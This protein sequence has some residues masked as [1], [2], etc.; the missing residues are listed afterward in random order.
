MDNRDHMLISWPS[1][2]IEGIIFPVIQDLSERFKIIVFVLSIPNSDSMKTKL[3]SMLKKKV[4]VDY[5]I[6]PKMMKGFLFHLYMKKSINLLKKYR[7]KLWLCSSDMQITE[8]YISDNSLELNVKK[9]CLWPPITYLFMYNQALAKQLL[10]DYEF[11]EEIIDSNQSSI[12]NKFRNAYSRNKSLMSSIKYM[13]LKKAIIFRFFSIK[14]RKYLSHVLNRY[15][16]PLLMVGKI[17]GTSKLERMTQLSSG[18]ATAYIFF[19]DYEVKAHKKLYR[20]NNIFLSYIRKSSEDKYADKKILG[21]LS[22]WETHKLLEQNILD[23]YVNDFIK[24]CELYNTNSIDLRPHPDMHPNSN[25]ASQIVEALVSKGINCEITS[26]DSPVI[27]QSEKYICV[28]GFASASLRDI[29]L[30]NQSIGVIGFES[31]SKHY[32]SDPKFAF[33]SSDGIDWLNSN[34]DIVKSNKLNLN[35]RLS[36]SEV[37]NKVYDTTDLIL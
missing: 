37:I 19:D 3:D 17:Y 9:I 34:G 25:Y 13:Y 30:F 23:M 20:N 33:G 24:V 22:G 26:S 7:I 28:A 1:R 5:Y 2:D 4:I 11:K 35:N 31:V 27:E 8:K 18:D 10:S 21:I 15:I 12:R 32:F 6:T 14:T 36:V 29:R 16:Y